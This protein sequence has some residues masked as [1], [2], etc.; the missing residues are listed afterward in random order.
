MKKFQIFIALLSLAILFIGAVVLNNTFL[1]KYRLDLT[2]NQVYTLSEGSKQIIEQVE[3]PIY[4]YFFFS[5]ENSE[6]MT[7]IRNY[8]QR[9]QSL[10]EEY[11]SLSDGNIKL[12]IIDPAPFSEAEDN[13]EEFGLTAAQVGSL[14]EKLYF[15]LGAR[16]A[17]DKSETI[18]F[19][20]PSKESFLEYDISQLLQQLV[21]PKSI[22][23]SLLTGLP[24]SGSANTM[25]PMM[26]MQQSQPAWVFYQQLE[27]LY[28][29]NRVETVN[30]EIPANTDVLLLINP[31]EM[32]ENLQYSIDQYVMNG[33]K[34]LIFIDPLNE[35][36]G[37]MP[38][39]SQNTASLLA[40]WGIEY[41]PD[42]VLDAAS[43]LEIRLAS[44]A[45]GKHYGYLGLHSQ[46][47]NQN[48]AINAQL[49]S[50]NG[51]SFGS[52]MKMDKLKDAQFEPLLSSSSSASTMELEQ[53][54]AVVDPNQLKVG[55][56]PKNQVY[57]LAVRV[58]GKISSAFAT[59]DE[60]NQAANFKSE[61]DKA[62]LIV[63]ADSDILA[64]RF[65]VQTSQF[66]GEMVATPFANNGDFV[67]NA[68]ENLSGSDELISIRARGK[69]S[70]PFTRVNELELKAEVQFRQ[71]EEQLQQ[72]LT[73]TEN[74]LAQLQGQP[75]E[76]NQLVL[77]DKQQA[78]IDEFAKQRVK[79]RKALR[80]VQHQLNKDIEALGRWL[81]FINIAVAPL[82]L[83]LLLFVFSLLLKRRRLT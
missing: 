43:A 24:V 25:N 13:A 16:N 83:T 82:C 56:E 44:G 9:V 64:D 38:T 12:E 72:K 61:T 62:N 53:Y 78:A 60:L 74:Q 63:V 23:V 37:V 76:A 39:D 11:A 41:N 52:L 4:F 58:N 40:A 54:Q 17:F 55:F 19:F 77:N 2:Q 75:L 42:I 10:L 81:K 80:E 65:W 6:G 51:A 22:N 8:A 27:Q 35:S 66:F 59:N 71:K 28:Q 73:E 14:G 67:A 34:A 1:A 70:R 31:N 30:T 5:Q 36:T 3:D 7:Q 33:G 49:E 45:A 21:A 46:N 79:I 20:E 32:N 50:I 18:A 57:H 69:F 26:A 68:V 15:G 29:I 48:D 47:I